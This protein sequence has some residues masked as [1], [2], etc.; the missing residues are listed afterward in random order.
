MHL[1]QPYFL[2]FNIDAK[3]TNYECINSRGFIFARNIAPPVSDTPAST[4]AANAPPLL[5]QKSQKFGL[6][7]PLVLYYFYITL[8]EA[9]SR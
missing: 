4:N 6:K 5:P 9:G 3:G 2:Y 7:F 8:I 1:N